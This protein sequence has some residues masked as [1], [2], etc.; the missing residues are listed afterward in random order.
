M[1][2]LTYYLE[3]SEDHYEALTTYSINEIGE[4]G[5]YARQLCHYLVRSGEQYKLIWNEMDADTEILTLKDIG[6]AISYGDERFNGN[7]DQI[8][9]EFRFVTEN[10]PMI[11]IATQIVHTHW[12]VIRY[13][14]KDNVPIPGKGARNV[15]SLEIDEDRRC[16]VIY[17][18]PTEEDVT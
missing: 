14:L 3:K 9:I 18:E 10:G 5:M 16:Y 7:N 13:L 4:D 6:K 17:V 8:L 11:C 12:E 1:K 15:D 2:Y